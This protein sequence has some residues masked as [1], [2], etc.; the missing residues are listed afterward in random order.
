MFC[1]TARPEGLW[2]VDTSKAVIVCT[3]R[4]QKEQKLF[5]GKNLIKQKNE[6]RKGGVRK[7]GYG[8]RF[9]EKGR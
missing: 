8:N 9:G 3:V 2:R 4:M 7:G 5:V 1:V 6:K